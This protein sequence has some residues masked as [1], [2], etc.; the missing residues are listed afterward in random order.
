M[1][2]AMAAM[3]WPVS[4]EK[5]VNAMTRTLGCRTSASPASPSPVTTV[6]TPVGR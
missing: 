3:R 2:A 6:T 5:P 4:T 1:G